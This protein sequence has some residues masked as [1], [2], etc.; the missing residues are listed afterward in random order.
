M[1]RDIQY[2]FAK[3]GEGKLVD[4]LLLPYV[5][6]ANAPSQYACLGCGQRLIAHLKDDRRQRHFA[7]YRVGTC[8][9]ETYLHQSAKLAFFTTYRDC[10]QSGQPFLLRVPVDD[11]C[12]GLY[13]SLGLRCPWSS[14]RTLDLTRWFDAATI[15]GN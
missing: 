9:V 12:I 8:S 5:R 11:N 6:K 3:D 1:G 7:H 14:T 10:L 15:E 2:R 13:S 4:V